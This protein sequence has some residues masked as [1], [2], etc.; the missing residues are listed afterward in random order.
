M[1]LK[2]IRSAVFNEDG[3]KLFF[4]SLPLETSLN[5]ELVTQN[6][7]E[8]KEKA[9]NIISR[10]VCE[11]RGTK[12][13]Y[14]TVT[15]SSSCLVCT[16]ENGNALD[17]CI[18]VSDK[19]AAA[20][21]KV[22]ANALSFK[23]AESLTGLPA[24]PYLMLPKIMWVKDNCPDIYKLTHKFLSPNDFL[25]AWLTGRF[26]TDI[27][28]AQ[29]Y[30]YILEQNR[31]PSEL[32]DEIG[33]FENTLPEVVHPGTTAGTLIPELADALCFP[34]HSE[35]PKIIVTSYDAICSF[36][37]SGTLT[38]GEGSDV[39]GT[40][41]AFRVY[42]EKRDLKPTPKVFITP[43]PKWNLSIVGGSNNMGGSLIEWIKQC[44]YNSEEYPY[45]IMEKDAVDAP[46]GAG[47]LLF[48]PYLM[49]ERAPIWDT[50]ARGVF[51]GLERFHTRREM[52]RAVFESTGFIDLDFI[53]AVE[54]TGVKVKSIQFS[55]GLSRINKIAQIKA[56]VTGRE[57]KVLSELE[58]TAVGAA[59]LAL[60][61]QGVIPTL[62]E[63]SERFTAVRMIILPDKNNHIKYTE[64]FKLYKELY[65][66][67][68]ELFDKR[69][70]M[71]NT[72]YDKRKVT[73]ENL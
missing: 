12:I 11:L 3:K 50:N 28:N 71:I 66:T 40:V 15:S 4:T 44:Y 64:I 35:L 46:V 31:Y 2:S 47:G 38:E 9:V 60:V 20:Q 63:A 26:L 32:L 30:H 58:T 21:S 14:I 56:D 37:G 41:T 53:N 19:R 70:E 1:G 68:T 6:P 55:G 23:D 43:V 36:F 67:L 18:M 8:W 73:I 22:L 13:D 39:S 17:K 42:T 16:D 48:L 5:N 45:E 27:Y 51:F 69:I 54:E 61:S 10:S 34:G 7:S 29:K 33:I 24:D 25:I 62:K 57:I 49:G 52:T 65:K 59:I 72:V